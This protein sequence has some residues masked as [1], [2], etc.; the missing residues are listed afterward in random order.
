MM[1]PNLEAYYK[2]KISLL[3]DLVRALTDTAAQY[4]AAN[5]QSTTPPAPAPGPEDLT[6][7]E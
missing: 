5:Q 3:E 7:L 1:D 2:A 6:S 4:I